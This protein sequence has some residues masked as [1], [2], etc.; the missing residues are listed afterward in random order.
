M[1]VAAPPRNRFDE[2]RVKNNL[3]CVCVCV[4]V[5]VYVCVCVC[6][7]VCVCLCV[8]GQMDDATNHVTGFF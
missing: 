1:C 3:H 5:C 8:V 4:C 2:E 6:V 7:S